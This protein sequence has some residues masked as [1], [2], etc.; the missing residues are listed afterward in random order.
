MAIQF[1]N[2]LHRKCVIGFLPKRL[3]GASC[4]PR[5]QS[6]HYTKR[7]LHADGLVAR[8]AENKNLSMPIA[9]P[10]VKYAKPYTYQQLFLN[11][12]WKRLPGTVCLSLAAKYNEPQ[13]DGSSSVSLFDQQL[14]EETARHRVPRSWLPSAVCPGLTG[15]PAVRVSTT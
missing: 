15:I 14:L 9:L 10:P 3:K 11:S 12:C 5:Q 2:I 1:R 13:A 7:E 6:D 4:S 8:G